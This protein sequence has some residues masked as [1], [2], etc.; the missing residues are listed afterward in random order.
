MDLGSLNKHWLYFQFANACNSYISSMHWQ[1]ISLR[2]VKVFVFM[3]SAKRCKAVISKHKHVFANSLYHF[4]S[5]PAQVL[6]LK[7]AKLSLKHKQ[8]DVFCFQFLKLCNT[9][10]K[11]MA[12]GVITCE[13]YFVGIS[14][15]KFAAY[16]VYIDLCC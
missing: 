14:G 15:L 7:K 11:Y 13:V 10:E 9:A 3:S 8:S 5:L 1:K 4:F 6:L 16:S 12:C 2:A